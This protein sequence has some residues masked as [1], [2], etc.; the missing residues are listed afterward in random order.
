MKKPHM[1]WYIDN[2]ALQKI[3][4]VEVVLQTVKYTAR[5]L[6]YSFQTFEFWELEM[7]PNTIRSCFPLL[8]CLYT[9]QKFTENRNCGPHLVYEICIL[10]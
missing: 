10:E 4:N 8:A 5:F 7:E 6:Y 1:I 9:K 3:R 2:T